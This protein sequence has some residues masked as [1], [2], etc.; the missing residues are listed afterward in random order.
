MTNN[1][2]LSKPDGLGAIH[3]TR[4]GRIL[5]ALLPFD[6]AWKA[7]IRDGAKITWTTHKMTQD[8]A[9]TLILSAIFPN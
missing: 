3:V 1:I 6:G 9:V 5:G 8:A 7:G 4:E 2:T